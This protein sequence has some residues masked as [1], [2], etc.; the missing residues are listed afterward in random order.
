[1]I[2]PDSAGN[3]SGDAPEHVYTVQFTNEELWGAEEAEP[4]G[5]STSTSGSPTSS[6]PRR[7]CR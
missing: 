2:Y 4:N 1:M 5:S 3:G 7:S 6:P